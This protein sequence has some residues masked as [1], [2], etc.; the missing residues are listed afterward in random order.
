MLYSCGALYFYS[1]FN[2]KIVIC[3]S[4]TFITMEITARYDCTQIGR[5]VGADL[6]QL[7]FHRLCIWSWFFERRI[8]LFRHK[9]EKIDS[10]NVNAVKHYHPYV[11]KSR[12]IPSNTKSMTITDSPLRAHSRKAARNRRHEKHP[13]KKLP[14]FSNVFCRLNPTVVKSQA[15]KAHDINRQHL[16]GSRIAV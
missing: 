3:Y 1:W 11:R 5:R 10:S 4:L 2:N 16:L 15:L 14:L 12:P 9:V 7:I 8:D 13:L 6:N